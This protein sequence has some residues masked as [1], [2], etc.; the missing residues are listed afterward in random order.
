MKQIVDMRFDERRDS[1]APEKISLLAW[2][3]IH[4]AL[5]VDLAA[6]EGRTQRW[7]WAQG[8][9][10]GRWMATDGAAWHA[11][12]EEARDIA[13]Q[14]LTQAGYAPSAGLP[15]AIERLGRVAVYVE[16]FTAEDAVLA[17]RVA[18]GIG[19]AV[20]RNSFDGRNLAATVEAVGLTKDEFEELSRLVDLVELRQRWHEAFV[21]AAANRGQVW[22][23]AVDGHPQILSPG[24][25]GYEVA[26]AAVVSGDEGAWECY[27]DAMAPD[28]ES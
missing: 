13:S 24:Q 27:C 16:R 6:E 15:G 9:G 8:L 26:C 28:E 10:S 20:I 19:R 25:E 21:P 4:A 1:G 14:Y 2:Q 18:V 11:A 12:A 5:L 3:D 22:A 17:R 7:S 23:R